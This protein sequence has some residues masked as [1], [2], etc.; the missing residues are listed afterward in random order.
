MN[1]EQTILIFSD[2]D[3]TILDKENFSFKEI[4][5]FIKELLIE[6]VH[7]IPNSSK[8]K[9]EIINFNKDLSE[10]LPY[11]VE[12][13]AAI[14]DLH[15]INSSFPEKII[16]SRE[17]DE[18]LNIFNEKV[19]DKYRSKFRFIDN[20]DIK[21]KIEILGLKK[22]NIKLAMN[23]EFS[24]PL[25][26]KGKKKEKDEVFKIIENLGL[27][28]QEGGRIINL[29]DNVSKSSAMKKVVKIFKKIIKNKLITI[30]VGDNYNDL[31]MLKNS[32]L[33]CLVFNDN[34]TQEKLS[35]DNCLVSKKSAPG[36]WKEIVNLAL[37]KIKQ[38]D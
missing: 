31:E 6:N 17:K 25:L 29:C 37:D 14:Y 30:A 9:D 22:D 1:T 35:I 13:G 24:V 15:L 16:L 21:T 28:L 7:L 33:P 12:N 23:R 10:K 8:T 3:G 26:F 19:P 4:K 2:L 32:D 5:P 36:G 11:I 18:I 20:F 38:K 34:F 27:S